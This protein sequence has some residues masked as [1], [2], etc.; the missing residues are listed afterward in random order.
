MEAKHAR[1]E[2]QLKDIKWSLAQHKSATAR[3]IASL[4]VTISSLKSN[5]PTSSPS[6]SQP[7]STLTNVPHPTATPPPPTSLAFPW[8]CA[9]FLVGSASPGFDIIYTIKGDGLYKLMGGAASTTSF[10]STLLYYFSSMDRH[11]HDE[12]TDEG[13]QRPPHSSFKSFLVFINR[14]ENRS[15]AIFGLWLTTCQVNI[16]IGHI[17]TDPNGILSVGWFS[18]ST[19]F[20]FNPPF[21]YFLGRIR[22]VLSQMNPSDVSS[23]L[24]T[25]ILT[26]GISSMTP[27]I[28]LSMDTVK[29]ASNA[30]RTQDVHDQYSGVSS[31]QVSICSF[32]LIMMFI[33]VIIAPLSTITITT[34]DLIKLNLPR[35]LI[36]QGALLGLS[37]LLNLY[38]FAKMEEGERSNSIYGI[39]WTAVFLALIPLFLEFFHMIFYHAYRT[40]LSP[41]PQLQPSTSSGEISLPPSEN[42]SRDPTQGGVIDGFF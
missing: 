7:P 36:F 32:L 31:P 26:V 9:F 41:P 39:G 16:A 38:L 23:Y 24:S 3:K 19:V 15:L 6:P 14:R 40:T 21:L 20:W 4:A 42:L 33:K 29:C 1:V 25:N 2:K 27:M 10:G 13:G 8:R 11:D 22:N 12:S 35:R 17:H 37:F 28:Y 30:D 18:F 5:P 34:N